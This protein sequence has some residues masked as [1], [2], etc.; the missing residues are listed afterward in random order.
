MEFTNFD[1][2]KFSAA[3]QDVRNRKYIVGSINVEGVF[4]LATEPV[5]H[6]TLLQ[7]TAEADR[8][9]K[10][11]PGKAFIVMQLSS[12]SLVPVL[13]GINKF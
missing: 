11:Q 10:L 9:A 2:A 6:S 7:A 12:G 13:L 8:L 3:V 1:Q 4:S 5:R